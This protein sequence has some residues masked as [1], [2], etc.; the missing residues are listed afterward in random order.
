MSK[1]PEAFRTISEVAAWLDTPAHVLRFWETRFSEVRP[2]KRAGGRRYYRPGDMRL[3]GGIRY[4]LHDRGMTIRGVQK[5]LREEG[6]AHVAAYAQPLDAEARDMAPMP[7]PEDDRR[8][9]A[10]D[11]AVAAGD[12]GSEEVPG[13]DRAAPAPAS[14]GA[15]ERDGTRAAAAA[16][17]GEAAG[18]AAPDAP[19]PGAEADAPPSRP[20]PEHTGGSAAQDV[21]AAAGAREDDEPGAAAAQ[22]AERP[23][24]QERATPEEGSAATGTDASTPESALAAGG[25]PPPEDTA[26]TTGEAGQPGAEAGTEDGMAAP[27]A[28]AQSDLFSGRGGLGTDL[29]AE[30]P[31]LLDVTLTAPPL[32]ARLRERAMRRRLSRRHRKTLAAMLPRLRALSDRMQADGG[33]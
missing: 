15:E 12:A 14:E 2:V 5:L 22:D 23:A 1:A 33:D 30:D 28:S 13:Q 4:L 21:A 31:T 19:P 3:L 6:V 9:A 25:G 26:D 16:A 11:A 10:A 20:A 24:A 32:A 29:P 27:A 7:G 17:N 18:E 8:E